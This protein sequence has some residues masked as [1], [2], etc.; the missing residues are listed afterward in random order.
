MIS[1]FSRSIPQHVLPTS[2]PGGSVTNPAVVR[3]WIGAL[4]S[5]KYEQSRGAWR[6][7]GPNHACGL[8]VGLLETGVNLRMLDGARDKVREILGVSRDVCD[9]VMRA[10]DT[11]RTFAEIANWLESLLPVDAP[12]APALVSWD[13]VPW[14]PLVAVPA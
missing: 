2:M 10:N 8:M 13:S 3:R 11:G 4:R 14:Q 1:S 5:G 12:P 7:D 9:H 6:G